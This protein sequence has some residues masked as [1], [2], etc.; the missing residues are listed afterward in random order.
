MA[1][2]GT[3]LGMPLMAVS[4]LR[5]DVSDLVL[6]LFGRSVHPELFDVR[7]AATLRQDGYKAVVSLCDDGHLVSFRSGD[8]TI[9]E[10]L[11]GGEQ[12][13]PEQKRLFGRK[14]RGSRADSRVF[15]GGLRY[16][17]CY[18][19]EQ[20]EPGVFARLNE[21]LALDCRKADLAFR[22]PPGNRLAPA[23]LSLLKLDAQAD[24][25]LLHAFHT[26]PECHSVVRTQS[27]FEL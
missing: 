23:P 22:F 2:G 1:A 24:G 9:T 7:T 25:L 21:E 27:L 6:H 10:V 12:T 19:V 13:L 4:T 26:F 18:Q 15:P 3:E 20:L 8:Q 5:P 16:Q 17:V 14:F 11:A